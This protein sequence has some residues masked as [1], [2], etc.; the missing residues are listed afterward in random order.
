MSRGRRLGGKA[1]TVRTWEGGGK[2][3]SNL[4]EGIVVRR[5]SIQQIVG[6]TTTASRP[7][8]RHDVIFLAFDS[9][10]FTLLMVHFV[11]NCLSQ[12]KIEFFL[13]RHKEVEL[14]NYSLAHNYSCS[15]IML[16]VANF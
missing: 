1:V 11:L 3:G 4:T 6:N 7:C 13:K 14:H 8:P 12:F 5:P 16:C 9:Q 10:I 15:K 2:G